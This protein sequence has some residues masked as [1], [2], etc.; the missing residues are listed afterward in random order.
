[1]KR[2]IAIV[3]IMLVVLLG[4]E[5]KNIQKLTET[6]TET[7]TKQ[8]YNIMGTYICKGEIYNQFI[9]EYEEYIPAIRFYEDGKCVLRVYYIGGV[10]EVEGVYCIKNSEVLVDID[11][12][13]TIFRDSG[14][15]EKYM[16]DEYIFTITDEDHLVIDRSF[17]EV[18]PGDSFVR[19]S[20]D[21]EI[22]TAPEPE[23]NVLGRYICSSAYYDDAY[24]AVHI[25]EIPS[26]MF[27]KDSRCSFYVDQKGGEEVW[28]KYR[29][30]GDKIYV[31]EL[32]FF[33][34]DEPDPVR[35][36][37]D[38]EY[39]FTIVDEDHLTIDKGFYN[40]QAG[41]TFVRSK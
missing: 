36:N 16:D 22:S 34:T 20:E 28:G 31:S 21:L 37:M 6:D 18:N 15:G 13:Y 9:D 3:S 5:G 33:P 32:R 10:S 26:I 12:L 2:L 41:D 39:V 8:E 25:E 7:L 30:E 1:M 35:D 38:K 4:C 14:T 24:I 11:L 27:L 19:I 29:I 23:H 17:Y 40:V